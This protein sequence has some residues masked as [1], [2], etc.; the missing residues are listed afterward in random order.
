MEGLHEI[1][2]IFSA[3]KSIVFNKV[4]GAIPALGGSKIIELKSKDGKMYFEVEFLQENV[5]YSAKV[6][7]KLDVSDCKLSIF[8]NSL[9]LKGKSFCARVD[10]CELLNLIRN[11]TIPLDNL[12][13]Q[14][15]D[16]PKAV[17]ENEIIYYDRYRHIPYIDYL[18]STEPVVK[19]TKKIYSSNASLLL[20]SYGE[21]V[22]LECRSVE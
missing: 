6:D 3:P 8:E 2:T 21:I 11:G 16:F 22:S 20:H 15:W 13:K 19:Y 9:F 1:Y 14:K 4:L 7:S 12:I 10:I 17:F 18:E 5:L